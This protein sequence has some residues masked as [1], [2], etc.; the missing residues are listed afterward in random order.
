M[1]PEP[2]VFNNY[3]ISCISGNNLCILLL[4]KK[5]TK[6]KNISPTHLS[7]LS[8]S[9][10]LTPSSSAKVGSGD[11]CTSTTSLVQLDP[12]PA[13]AWPEPARFGAHQLGQLERTSRFLVICCRTSTLGARPSF[14]RH[15]G[16]PLGPN[17][18]RSAR[19]EEEPARGGFLL[20]LPLSYDQ[21][22]VP[23]CRPSWAHF[24][25]KPAQK[26]A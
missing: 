26:W 9:L 23:L 13:W 7:L 2:W 21:V 25:L 6:H 24:E 1:K 12:L 4:K 17:H 8:Y 15:G 22:V 18:P 11:H 20:V 5:T 3:F 14:P 10:S 16:A 19:V